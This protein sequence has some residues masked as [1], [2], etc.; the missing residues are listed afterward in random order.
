MV[1]MTTVER[2]HQS[3]TSHGLPIYLIKTNYVPQKMINM[4]RK[5]KKNIQLT[6]FIEINPRHTNYNN[7]KEQL[8]ETYIQQTD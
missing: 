8:T 6:Q 4:K 3:L 1:H 5:P 2:Q 7:I